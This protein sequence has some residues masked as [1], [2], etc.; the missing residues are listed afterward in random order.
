MITAGLKAMDGGKII[1]AMKRKPL[2]CLPL[3]K[4]GLES[5][6]GEEKNALCVGEI[7]DKHLVQRE[8]KFPLHTD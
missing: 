3:H 2:G 1:M 7:G 4:D 6:R 8:R 5:W